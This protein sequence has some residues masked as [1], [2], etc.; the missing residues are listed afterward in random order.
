MVTFEEELKK[1]QP[2]VNKMA[3]KYSYHYHL[4]SF[5][6]A[7]QE[8][9]LRLWES[10]QKYNPKKGVKFFTYAYNYCLVKSYLIKN[11]KQSEKRNAKIVINDMS[12]Y[13]DNKQYVLSPEIKMSI[14]DIFY[15]FDRAAIL[16]E[17]EECLKILKLKVE[18]FKLKEISEITKTPYRRVQH[19]FYHKVVPLTKMV[20]NH[21]I[22]YSLRWLERKNL[23]VA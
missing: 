8:V 21:G 16:P 5:E 9:L 17:Y 10:W 22:K 6:D 7:K 12:F 11:K 2:F 4:S 1:L 18:N 3:K 23:A 14:E 19:I 13:I 20:Y 15:V